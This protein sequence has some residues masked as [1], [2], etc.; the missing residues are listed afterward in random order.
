MIVVRFQGGLGNQLFQYAL[1]LSI[2]K[3]LNAQ[4]AIDV[5][6]YDSEFTS[7][8]ATKRVLYLDEFTIQQI[9][10]IQ[11][12]EEILNPQIV[13]KLKR[14]LER[15]LLPYYKNSYVIESKKGFDSNMV[16]I[17]VNSYLEGFWQSY[18][19]FKEIEIQLRQDLHLKK[20]ITPFAQDLLSKIKKYKNSI[21]VHVR[22]GDYINKYNH[23][24][25]ILSSDYYDKALEY[26]INYSKENAFGIFIFSDDIA[27]CRENLKFETESIFVSHENLGE[28]EELFLMQNCS[29]N[30]IA[31]S[32]F[33]WWGAWLNTNPNK[34]VVAPKKWFKKPDNN[35]DSTIYPASWISL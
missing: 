13:S 2:K 17:P 3:K 12:S 19:Y 6:F 5:S 1:A 28:V 9:P 23:F 16:K 33:S 20:T 32:T 7:A 35:F 24:Y 8:G 31:N 10:R 34:I 22:R 29:H 18:L 25:T 30:I 21:A 15:N 27:W 26:I 11:S 4:I 14:F